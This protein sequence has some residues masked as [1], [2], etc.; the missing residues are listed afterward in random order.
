MDEFKSWEEMTTLEKMDAEFWDFYK[1]VHGIRPRHVDRSGW[2]EA[3]YERE[4]EELTRVSEVNQQQRAEY[5]A[6]AAHDI[7]VRI[8]GLMNYGARNREMAIRWLDEAEDAGGDREY[9]CYL[10][11]LPYGYFE[12]Q[13][14]QN[15]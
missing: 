5:E 6:K 4:F 13:P 10:L 11:G 9:L 8:Q 14:I 3:D 12:P 2:S 15:A 1:S 7:E